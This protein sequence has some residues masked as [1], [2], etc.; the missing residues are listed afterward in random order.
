MKRRALRRGSHAVVV[1]QLISPLRYDVVVRSQFFE[2]LAAWRDEP[3]GAVLE[4]ARH[5]PY[6]VWFTSVE[7]ARFFPRLLTNPDLLKRRFDERVKRAMAML[8]SFELVGFDDRHPVTLVET[9][10]RS[11]ADSGAVVNQALHIADGCH[12]LALLL[13]AG[14]SLDAQMYRVRDATRPLLDNTA[15]LVRGLHLSDAD[16]ARF[17]SHRFAATEYSDLPSL[18]RAV[19]SRSPELLTELDGV[20]E[21]H[22]RASDSG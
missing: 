17:L 3:L 20:L 2:T 14:L 16:Y 21:V 1:R 22:G 4:G 15:I 13:M 5:E 11:V 10:G 8:R 9:N 18:R 7:C 12:R 19:A 6:F